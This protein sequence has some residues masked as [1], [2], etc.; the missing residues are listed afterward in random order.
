MYMLNTL[1]NYAENRK[2]DKYN[3][4][5]C[6]KDR[7]LGFIKENKFEKWLIESGWFPGVFEKNQGWSILDYTNIEEKIIIELKG[8]R[9]KKYSY[10]TTIIGY[11]KYLKARQLML[12]GYKV[13]FFFS[14]SDKLC[15]YEVPIILPDLIK[16]N[17]AGTK[18]RGRIEIKK[19]LFIPTMMLYDVIDFENY[20]KY[21]DNEE[22]NETI[23]NR[24]ENSLASK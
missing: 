17:D 1:G 15:F 22:I 23:K 20:S 12:K 10:D 7:R 19:H 8:R 9:C 13:F 4:I 2:V 21:R 5:N 18:R 3:H 14:F 11:N 16:I 6:K 24:N